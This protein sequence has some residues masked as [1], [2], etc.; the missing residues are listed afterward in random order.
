MNESLGKIC[1]N[2]VKG[3]Q[4]KINQPLTLS[5]ELNTIANAWSKIILWNHLVKTRDNV[6]YT[7]NKQFIARIKINHQLGKEV[8]VFNLKK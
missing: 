6:E 1:F 5:E 7:H 2:Y 8:I 3:Y 4:D